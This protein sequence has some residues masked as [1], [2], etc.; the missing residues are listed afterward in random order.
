VPE[1]SDLANLL[2]VAA[3]ETVTDADI[4]FFARALKEVVQ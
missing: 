1:K 3:T 4:D 2:L